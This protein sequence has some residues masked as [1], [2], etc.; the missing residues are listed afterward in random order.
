MTKTYNT[1]LTAFLKNT[2]GDRALGIEPTE[3]DLSRAV[4]HQDVEYL[5]SRYPYLQIMSSE[6]SFAEGYEVKLITLD[7]GWV[8]H[9]YGDAMSVSPGEL[10]Y[11]GGYSLLMEE[12][13]EGGAG[14]RLLNPGKGTVLKQAVDSAEQLMGTA[15]E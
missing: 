13:D 6:P 9:D 10:L 8:A 1:G 15:I 5:L 7:S 11:G 2:W 12:D 4:T 14:G 3:A